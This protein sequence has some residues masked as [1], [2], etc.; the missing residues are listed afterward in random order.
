[1]GIYT[2]KTVLKTIP[3]VPKTP[4]QSPKQPPKL[5]PP[6][7]EPKTGSIRVPI[8]SLTPVPPTT[9]PSAPI[10]PSL[11]ALQP[12]ANPSTRPQMRNVKADES[13]TDYSDYDNPDLSGPDAGSRPNPPPRNTALIW[14]VNSSGKYR[15]SPPS[16]KELKDI[17]QILPSPD[18]PLP[19][20]EMLMRATRH[21]QLMGADYRF[22]LQHKLGEGYDEEQLIQEV[23]CLNPKYDKP[24]VTT[25]HKKR[26]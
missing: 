4:K 14:S 15:V 1:M 2:P 22:I 20:V 9:P 3:K 5:S 23:P 24:S 25:T 7:Y 16:V 6:P 19:F 8:I 11:A 12:K 13:D 10:Y 26:I 18:K 17:L 21:C